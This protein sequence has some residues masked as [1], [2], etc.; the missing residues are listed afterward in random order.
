MAKREGGGTR[1]THR[2]LEAAWL[3]GVLLGVLLHVLC[4]PHSMMQRPYVWFFIGLSV[5]FLVLVLW[6][7]ASRRTDKS[8]GEGP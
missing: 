5:F 1:R 2:A 3:I 4:W 6:S 8:S 7:L